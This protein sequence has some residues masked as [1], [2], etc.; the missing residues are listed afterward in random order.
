MAFTS[1]YPDSVSSPPDAHV[2]PPPTAYAPR[3]NPSLAVDDGL[4]APQSPLTL[5]TS[6]LWRDIQAAAGFGTRK[7]RR[8]DLEMGLAPE[9]PQTI[10]RSPVCVFCLASRD[11]CLHLGVNVVPVLFNT[12]GEEAWKILGSLC[13]ECKLMLRAGSG[14]GTF[15]A[16]ELDVLTCV[17]SS[18]SELHSARCLIEAGSS[19]SQQVA[20]DSTSHPQQVG[21]VGA[22][23]HPQNVIPKSNVLFCLGGTNNGTP[24]WPATAPCSQRAMSLNQERELGHAHNSSDTDQEQGTSPTS[25]RG[26]V[27]WGSV[28]TLCGSEC[29]DSQL[30]HAAFKKAKLQDDCI[31]GGDKIV[32]VTVQDLGAHA[33]GTILDEK[34]QIESDTRPC[35]VTFEN[36]YTPRVVSYGG[37]F[38]SS[39]SSRTIVGYNDGRPDSTLI[40]PDKTYP[41]PYRGLRHRLFIVYRR[42]FSLVFLGNITALIII[43]VFP[44]IDRDWTGTVS[45][46]NLTIAVLVRQDRVIN[47]LYA[48]FCSVPRS[49]P[50][51]IRQQ[52]AKIYHLGGVHS[53][54]A[55]AAVVWFIA[56]VAY[57]MKRPAKPSK[58]VS[59]ET[60]VMSWT[61]IVLL[62]AMLV[63]AYPTM[64]KRYHN[65]FE[66]V[67][68]F[69]G[70]TALGIFWAQSIL[71]INDLRDAHTQTLGAAC[72]RSP[73]FWLLMVVTLSIASP[74][75][76]LRKVDVR[77]EVLSDHA[78][79]LHFDYVT[80]VAGSFTR[81]SERP[82]IEWHSFA[83]I[84][85]L[86]PTNKQQKGYS[87]V[88]SNAGDWTKR[89]IQHPPTKLWIRGLPS[90]FQ[91]SICNVF[92]LTS[93][94]LACGVMHV[95]RLFNRLVL[96]GTGSGIGPLLSFLQARPVPVRLI[97]STPNPIRTFGEEICKDAVAADP[98]CIIH[99]TKL[100]GRPDLVRM[101]YQAAAE[102]EAEAVII[103]ANEKITKKVVYGLETRGLAAYGAIWDS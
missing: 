50:L 31:N 21:I 51:W 80:P 22:E 92:F 59:V 6:L 98:D 77:S 67:H 71:S 34:N 13:S 81:M 101:A 99:D 83:V 17:P 30:R 18:S 56:S 38:N 32:G 3:Q 66:L 57:S 78:V 79:R 102:F 37:A 75:F 44:Q 54:A 72:V 65:R 47:A 20:S 29:D 68:R 74:W 2:P 12:F 94:F 16:R 27:S 103:I 85:M 39:R 100:L 73:N 42:L 45:L 62:L 93:G 8:D 10:S 90:E 46:I 49:W 60:L 96:V 23:Q 87:V 28:S 24:T 4:G 89:Q 84:P 7:R 91:C 26:H 76:Y 48:V 15:T 95:A 55:T 58:A 64:R 25:R 61:A 82:L 40:I 41:Q 86:E 69:A 1:H 88:V 70:W 5:H 52:C 43:A 35:S 14:D 63:A 19:H 97:W 11:V 53:G 33:S 36:D 9:S